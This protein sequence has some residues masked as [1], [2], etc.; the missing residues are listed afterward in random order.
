MMRSMIGGVIGFGRSR[1]PVR[2]LKDVE[3]DLARLNRELAHYN[4]RIAYHQRT[5]EMIDAKRFGQN[6]G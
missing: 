2:S 4:E 6:L 1:K 3:R 5:R